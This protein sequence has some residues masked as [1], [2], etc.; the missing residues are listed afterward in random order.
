MLAIPRAVIPD[1]PMPDLGLEQSDDEIDGMK[2][3]E[4]SS[5]TNPPGEEGD[6][7]E[8]PSASMEKDG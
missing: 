2:A 4:V 5:S 8:D 3:D 1:H 6:I 7:T